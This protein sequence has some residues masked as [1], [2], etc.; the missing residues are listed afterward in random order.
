MADMSMMMRMRTGPPGTGIS[1]KS[2]SEDGRRDDDS[3][4][5]WVAESTTTGWDSDDSEDEDGE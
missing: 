4:G 1:D 2:E 5:S 3:A